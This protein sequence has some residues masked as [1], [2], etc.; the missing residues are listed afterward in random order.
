VANATPTATATPTPDT[1]ALAA[2]RSQ[3][4]DVCRQVNAAER[5]RRRDLKRLRHSVNAAYTTRAQRDA[6]LLATRRV[7]SRGGRNLADLESL[8]PPAES[9]AL[10]AEAVRVWNRNLDRQ[11]A[12][13]ERLDSAS[14]RRELLGAIAPWTRA[15]PASERDS[16]TL[17]ADL[18]RLGGS[19]CRIHRFSETPIPLPPLRVKHQDH[20]GPDVAPSGAAGTNRTPQTTPAPSV[21]TPVPSGPDVGPAPTPSAPDVAP[22]GG[23]AGGG[24]AGGGG[25]D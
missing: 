3:V 17:T 1:A 18:Q 23:G 10:Q 20:G 12:F 21:P 16:V 25:N 4:V 2:Y 13:G 19:S 11:R 7:I 5:A 22:G 14:G 24:G 15:R 6:I 9:A 8:E